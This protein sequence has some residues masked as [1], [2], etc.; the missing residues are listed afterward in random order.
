MCNGDAYSPREELIDGCALH[1]HSVEL[2]ASSVVYFCLPS[3]NSVKVEGNLHAPN[4][5]FM[6]DFHDQIWPNC[7]ATHRCQ[8]HRQSEA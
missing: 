6:L 8:T 3:A 5:E 2:N 7:S 4:I 1:F